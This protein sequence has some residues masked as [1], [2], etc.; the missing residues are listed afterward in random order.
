MSALTE[1][2][3]PSDVTLRPA[4][5]RERRGAATLLAHAFARDPLMR[6]AT[7]RAEDPHEAGTHIFRASI[8]GTLFAGGELVL[9]ER[10]DVVIGA[11][12]IADPTSGTLARAVRANVA[13]LVSGTRFLTLAHRLAPGALTLLNNADQASRRLAPQQP[14]HVLVAV[15]VNAAARG[16]GV[17]RLLV[18]HVVRRAQAD[19]LSWGVRL[20]TEN[21]QNVDRYA[22]WGFS[23][24]GVVPTGSV[25]VHV[26]AQAT[27]T[28]EEH[29]E[30]Q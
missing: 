1:S 25:D 12:L 13:R 11:A 9:A 29:E 8:D 30:G 22:R 19:S 20:E 16:L 18:E 17:G 21:P 28:N 14:H 7:G 10:R 26:M 5:R 27:P 24:L 3:P 15:G 6:A 4:E 23:L 2:S